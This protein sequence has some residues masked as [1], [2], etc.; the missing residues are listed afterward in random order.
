MNQILT[1][2]LIALGLASEPLS[3]AEKEDLQRIS[4]EYRYTTQK[5]GCGSGNA[6]ADC[7]YISVLNTMKMGEQ[8]LWPIVTEPSA[9]GGA[10]HAPCGSSIDCGDGDESSMFAPNVRCTLTINNCEGLDVLETLHLECR[11]DVSCFHEYKPARDCCVVTGA[12]HGAEQDPKKP[13]A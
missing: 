1:G 10:M 2:L 4:D 3:V 11:G 7:D 9:P 6:D 12:T 5:Y 8:E 13:E